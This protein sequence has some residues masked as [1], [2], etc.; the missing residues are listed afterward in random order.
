MHWPSLSSCSTVYATSVLSCCQAL[1]LL[2]DARADPNQRDPEYQACRMALF[3]VKV[4]HSPRRSLFIRGYC[5]INDLCWSWTLITLGPLKWHLN[6]LCVC[7]KKWHRPRSCRGPRKMPTCLGWDH[8]ANPSPTSAKWQSSSRTLGCPRAL[9]VW[10][11][12]HVTLPQRFGQ[13]RQDWKLPRW[14][15]SLHWLIIEQM[16]MQS[17]ERWACHG[18]QEVIWSYCMLLT[19]IN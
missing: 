8:D 4:C 14:M 10:Q 7:H 17:Q 5:I 15:Q 13:E 1:E 18:Y 9:G 3:F 6:A 12:N 11:I 16:S 19:F 2:L